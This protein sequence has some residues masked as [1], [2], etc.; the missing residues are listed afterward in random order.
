MGDLQA[1]ADIRSASKVRVKAM[2]FGEP[3]TNV[4]A[5]DGNPRRFSYFVEYNVKSHKRGG[6]KHNEYYANCTDRKGN[7]WNADI[8]V[9]YS[10]HLDADKCKELFEPVWQSQFGS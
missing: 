10:G 8:D 2:D 3:V 4:C 5:G 9:I 7:F 6:I 1:R